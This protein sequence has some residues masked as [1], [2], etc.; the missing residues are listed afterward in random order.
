[1]HASTEERSTIE[2]I[3]ISYLCSHTS[4]SI[5]VHSFQSNFI[6]TL[7]EL[8]HIRIY[9][10]VI[11]LDNYV[12]TT[13]ISDVHSYTPPHTLRVSMFQMV[14]MSV[15]FVSMNTKNMS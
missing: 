3:I 12:Q 4:E 13:I 9:E 6:I 15:L 7:L 1:M 8:A 10:S 5:T 14:A 2:H 11:R